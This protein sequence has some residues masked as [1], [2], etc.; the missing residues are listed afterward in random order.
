MAKPRSTRNSILKSLIQ[1]ERKKVLTGETLLDLSHPIVYGWRRGK[2]YLYIGCS[3][4]GVSRIF[5]RDDII[6]RGLQR[7]DCI[8]IWTFRGVSREELLKIEKNLIGVRKPLYNVVHL[9]K[10]APNPQLNL[11]GDPV[12]SV[13]QPN[14]ATPAAKGCESHRG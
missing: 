10:A 5:G 4:R 14:Q 2:Q 12:A 11:L 3:M 1:R 6:G 7:S 8:D 9:P 13:R